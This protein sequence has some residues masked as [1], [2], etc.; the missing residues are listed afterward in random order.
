MHDR[1]EVFEQGL[2]LLVPFFEELDFVLIAAPCD[3][4]VASCRAQFSWGHHL[5][6]LSHGTRLD[7]VIYTIGTAS[8][9]HGAY[10]RALGVEHDARFTGGAIEGVDAYEALLGDLQSRLMPYFE[11]PDREF[12]ELAEVHGFRGRPAL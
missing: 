4:D 3:P 10:L 12:M 1:Q 6:S 9:E 2:A 7:Q 5:V 11:S 8:I